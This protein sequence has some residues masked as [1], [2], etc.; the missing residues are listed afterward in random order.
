[1][2]TFF[3]TLVAVFLIVVL[4]AI[5]FI[6]SGIYDVAATTRDPDIVRWILEAT[7][8]QSI[9]VRADKVVPPPESVLKDPNTIRTG[10]EHYNEMCVACHG[11]PGVQASEARAGLNPKPP[12]LAKD[13]EDLPPREAFWIIKHGIKMT[14]MPAWGPT[15]S[16][17]KIW[18]I[19]A[20][21][22][23]LP[24]ISPGEYHAMQQET[25]ASGGEETAH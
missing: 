20:F 24:T 14:G 16:D 6:Y 11:A 9:E 21:V 7:R 23:Q 3:S 22:K 5:F 8:E 1:M 17:A 19:V 25:G 12:L 13:A 18:A 4:C 2:K 10:F 15:H